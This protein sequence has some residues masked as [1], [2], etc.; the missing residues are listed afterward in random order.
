MLQIFSLPVEIYRGYLISTPDC[1]TW[2]WKIFPIR[3]N[4]QILSDT[5]DTLS[6]TTHKAPFQAIGHRPSWPVGVSVPVAIASQRDW[7]LHSTKS[8]SVVIS[9]VASPSQRDLTT[10]N[11]PFFK[12]KTSVYPPSL[13][14]PRTF[15]SNFERIQRPTPMGGYLQNI[16][17]SERNPIIWLRQSAQP[18]RRR[19]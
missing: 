17:R 7:I 16:Q 12:K 6:L 18:M 10:L 2:S 13:L 3:D 14:A 8:R 9:H 5:E 11:V 19:D 4:Y 15:N 1:R